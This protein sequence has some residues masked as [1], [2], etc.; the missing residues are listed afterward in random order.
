MNR[1]VKQILNLYWKGPSGVIKCN[2][3]YL[4]N[5]LSDSQVKIMVQ[6]IIDGIAKKVQL[7]Y[8]CRMTVEL[9]NC[10]LLII[11]SV[12]VIPLDFVQGDLFAN[13]SRGTV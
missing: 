8:G 6:D 13:L 12:K 2:T 1:M 3:R 11:G 5:D 4:E 7:E 10:E 9:L